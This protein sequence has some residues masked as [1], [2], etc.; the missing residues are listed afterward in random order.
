M[1][2]A[3]GKT[4]KPCQIEIGRAFRF[5]VCSAGGDLLEIDSIPLAQV[6]Q[7]AVYF[8]FSE[9]GLEKETPVWRLW[10]PAG[11]TT[12]SKALQAFLYRDTGCESANASDRKTLSQITYPFH[13]RPSAS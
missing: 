9:I 11:V 13:D 4:Q 2:V 5:C 3:Q 6:T 8:V 10:I 1:P 12:K 7:Q